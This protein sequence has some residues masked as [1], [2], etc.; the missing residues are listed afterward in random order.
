MAH[1]SENLTATAALRRRRS[2]WFKKKRRVWPKYVLLALFL[3]ICFAIV[4][5]IIGQNLALFDH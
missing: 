5:Y 2:K 3:A 1:S 4:V